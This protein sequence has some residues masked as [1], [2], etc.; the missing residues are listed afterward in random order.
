L[1]TAFNGRVYNHRGLRRELGGEPA[2][3]ALRRV[4]EITSAIGS[5]EFCSM[6][7]PKYCPMHNPRDVD[8]EEIKAVL[9]RRRAA[10]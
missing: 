3:R 2:L 6:C 1:T 4:L 10:V 7:G 8:R 9:E 5:A